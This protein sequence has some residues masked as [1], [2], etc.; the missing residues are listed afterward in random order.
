[1]S[2]GRWGGRTGYKMGGGR[3]ASR[4]TAVKRGETENCKEERGGGWE[5]TY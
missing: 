4:L 3:T 1:M 5:W 2:E